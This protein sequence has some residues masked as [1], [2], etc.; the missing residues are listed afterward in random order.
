MP[1]L[2]PTFEIGPKLGLTL[3][4]GSDWK[5]DLRLPLRAVFGVQGGV[6]SRG[7]TFS[8]VLNLDAR[9]QGW[10][11]GLQGGPLAASRTYHAYYYN[12]DPAYATAQRP[13]YR[14]DSGLAGWNATLSA[15]R[16]LGDWWLAGFVRRDSLSG[17]TFADSPLVTQRS[18][19]IF[20][21]AA[22]WIF[23]VSDER[24]AD[25]R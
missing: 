22:S 14:A 24:V 9:M 12:V 25:G 23:K 6:Q 13:A 17:A 21:V 16:R 20:G 3:A 10:N 7:L 8:P 15:S 1:N 5:L 11:V 19:F 4:R 2:A 18:Q